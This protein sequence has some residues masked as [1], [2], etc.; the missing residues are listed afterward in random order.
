MTW[1]E[2]GALAD[3]LSHLMHRPV[4]IHHSGG[5]LPLERLR[6]SLMGGAP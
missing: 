3:A 1:G 4:T 2:T 5:L 6:A